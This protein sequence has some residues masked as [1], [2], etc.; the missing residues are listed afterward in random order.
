MLK[1]TSVGSK[2]DFFPKFLD[3]YG[4]GYGIPVFMVNMVNTPQPLYNTT[5]VSC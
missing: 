1:D 3:K 4:K 5:A 2:M